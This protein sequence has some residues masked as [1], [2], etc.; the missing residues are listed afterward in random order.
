[1]IYQ[2]TT[3]I[4]NMFSKDDLIVN[5]W[6]KSNTEYKYLYLKI[7]ITEPYSYIAQF[8]LTIYMFFH[9]QEVIGTD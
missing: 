7:I 1:M 4:L 2:G 8:N 6:W 3:H 9:S 5:C